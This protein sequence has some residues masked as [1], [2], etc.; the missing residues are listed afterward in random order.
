MIEGDGHLLVRRLTSVAALS[1]AEKEAVCRLPV[2]RRLVPAR[3]DIVK[4]GERP[5]HC[6]LVLKGFAFRYKLTR[7]G[8]RQILQIHVPGDMPDLQSLDLPVLDHNLAA[9]TPTLTGEVAHDHIHEL[10]RQFPRLASVF[11]RLN[12][13]DASV[14]RERVVTLG[15]RP[16]L[17]RLAHFLCEMFVRLRSV[18]LTEGHAMR[19]PITQPELADALGLSYVHVNRMMQELRG[20]GLIETGRDTVMLPNWSDLANLAEFDDAYLHLTPWERPEPV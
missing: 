15:Q 17:S 10:S 12:L 9:L 7:S 2:E 11:W 19:L 1:E 16:A 18:G 20:K 4:E 13:I 14:M 6:C 5:T 8:G 3:T